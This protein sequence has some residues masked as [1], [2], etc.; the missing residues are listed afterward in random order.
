[1]TWKQN[2]ADTNDF[3]GPKDAPDGMIFLHQIPDGHPQLINPLPLDP[4][5]NAVRET[6]PALKD[7][8][9]QKWIEEVLKHSKIPDN[10]WQEP[11]HFWDWNLYKFSTWKRTEEETELAQYI[12]TRIQDDANEGDPY[13]I[14]GIGI[15]VY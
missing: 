7:S 10:S 6:Y 2:W 14:Q 5:Y 1:M 3:V 11:E 13:C 8:D 4:M 12:N 15:V 9:A